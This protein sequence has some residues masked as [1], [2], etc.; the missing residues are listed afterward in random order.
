MKIKDIRFEK[1]VLQKIFDKH[2]LG[3]VKEV[4]Y[5]QSG[6]V[7]PVVHINNNYIIKVNSRDP[8]DPKLPR[9]K[10]AMEILT[11]AIYVPRFIVLDESKKELKYDYIIM[12]QITGREVY[13][14]WQILNSSQKTKLSHQA[15]EWLNEIHQIKFPKFGSVLKEGIHFE[16]WTEYIFYKLNEAIELCRFYHLFNETVFYEIQDIFLHNKTCLD[17]VKEAVFV[18]ND[19]HFGNLLYEENKLTG[20]IDFEWCLAGDP[21][22]DLRDPFTF[23]ESRQPFMAGYESKSKQ[24]P[25]F[26]DKLYLYQLLMYLQLSR[27]AK[28]H[29]WGNN[30][31]IKYTNKVYQL[32]KQ[33]Q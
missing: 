5:S 29:G 26:Y 15:G 31:F 25:E 33:L 8:D 12:S 27:L 10:R 14:D 28:Q 3:K 2:H 13:K 24:S 17:S 30:S 18:H 23:P 32:I 4:Y 20:V 9:E 1:N 19:F 6:K 7:N 11:N 21:E 16:T 22:Y